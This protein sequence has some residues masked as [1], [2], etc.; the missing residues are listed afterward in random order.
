MRHPGDVAIS[1]STIQFTNDAIKTEDAFLELRKVGKKS[2]LEY[3]QVFL[4]W[5]NC[6]SDIPIYK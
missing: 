1:L 6:I 4:K 3:K 2:V 5:F